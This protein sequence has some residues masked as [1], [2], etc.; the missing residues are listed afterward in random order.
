MQAPVA[1][2]TEL[3]VFETQWETGKNTNTWRLNTI[4][5]NQR[6]NNEIKKEIEEYIKTNDN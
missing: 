2:D 6:V 4:V 5:N 3:F 1:H